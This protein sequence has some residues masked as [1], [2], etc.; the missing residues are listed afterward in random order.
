MYIDTV[1]EPAVTLI[2][3]TFVSVA[4]VALPKITLLVPVEP[5]YIRLNVG[6]PVYVYEVACGMLTTVAAF[7]VMFMLFVPK[8]IALVVEPLEENIP[9]VKLN[10][11]KFNVPVVKVNVTV[12]G[13][14][15]ASTSCTVPPIELTVIGGVKVTL[16]LVTL[17]VFLPLKVIAPVP[18][19]VVPEPFSQLP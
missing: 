16:L 4:P 7:P 17:C 8:A 14:V 19:K 6:V 1:S 3:G 18:V 9:Q 5:E 11:F 10:P 13:R 2:I 12:V 15:R